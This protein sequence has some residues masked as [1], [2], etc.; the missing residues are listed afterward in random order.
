MRRKAT[1]KTSVVVTLLERLACWVAITTSLIFS[2][3]PAVSRMVTR[4]QLTLGL[5]CMA[6]AGAG[7]PAMIVAATGGGSVAVAA[8]VGAGITAMELAVCLRMRALSL[9]LESV[10]FIV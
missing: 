2:T 5:S 10:G 3:S 9:S 7:G 4:F 1:R 6:A 8:G